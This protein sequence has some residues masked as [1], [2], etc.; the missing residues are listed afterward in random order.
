MGDILSLSKA[1]KARVRAEARL[2]AA[3]NRI[4]HGRTKA[5]R[6]AAEAVAE[7]GA[8]TLDGHKIEPDR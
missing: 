8:R 3:A 2:D 4:R 7:Q 5:E 6:A 1:R